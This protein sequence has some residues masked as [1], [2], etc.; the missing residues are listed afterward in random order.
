MNK[1]QQLVF[2]LVCRQRFPNVPET[3]RDIESFE[4]WLQEFIKYTK[5]YSVEIF[6]KNYA[7][8]K[9]GDKIPDYILKWE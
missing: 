8:A 4:S 1:D 3:L 9:E 5:S 2:K 7:T 6:D